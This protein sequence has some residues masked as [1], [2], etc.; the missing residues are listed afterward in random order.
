MR[1]NAI[2]NIA[3]ICAVAGL[4]MLYYA[5]IQPINISKI[6]LDYVGTSVNVCG[7]IEWKSISNNHVFMELGD[8]TGKIRLVIFNTTALRLNDSGFDVYGISRGDNICYTGIV[9]EYPEGSGKLELIYRR[10]NIVN[11]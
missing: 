2:R 3:L 4:I 10:G 11:V 5:S 8:I 1:E 6:T 7:G 9:E